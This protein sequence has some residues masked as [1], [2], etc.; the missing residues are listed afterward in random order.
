MTIYR[1]GPLGFLSLGT[2]SVPGNA[3][4]RDQ[5]MALQW[6]N[7]N[8]LDFGGDPT[9]IWSMASQLE[10]SPAPITCSH[11]LAGV[12]S[13]G[14]FYRV[15]LVASPLLIIILVKKEQLS[16]VCFIDGDIM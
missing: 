10:A 6:V 11:H 1:L 7:D 16:E 8:I 14:L 12:S 3:V 9:Q 15:D 5:V 4:V 13:R 2:E